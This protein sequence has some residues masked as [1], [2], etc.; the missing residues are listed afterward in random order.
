MPAPLSG[1]VKGTEGA[2]LR[3][4]S[5]LARSSSNLSQPAHCPGRS[6]WGCDRGQGQHP[7]STPPPTATPS[8]PS[9]GVLEDPGTHAPLALVE[10]ACP[11]LLTS[12]WDGVGSSVQTHAAGLP[13]PR[14]PPRA[15]PHKPAPFA[16]LLV[17]VGPPLGS[18]PVRTAVAWPSFRGLSPSSRL[19]RTLLPSRP[20]TP[21]LR[22]AS[23]QPS[24]P[25]QAR[26]LRPAR[27]RVLGT[28]SAGLLRG[29]P[30]PV[31]QP[32]PR[33]C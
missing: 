9:P 5:F 14:P 3:E 15:G 28:R 13:F 25:S 19:R 32:D 18:R 22:T 33:T 29:A 1:E 8:G 20:G 17:P 27:L 30:R 21:P 31:L 6:P 26:R 10:G 16:C 7:D 12:L 11:L 2:T 24:Y 23:G 4:V